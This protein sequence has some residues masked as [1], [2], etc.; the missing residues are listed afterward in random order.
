MVNTSLCLG[1]RPIDE[2]EYAKWMNLY[3]LLEE[4]RP[5][6]YP[7]TPHITLAYYSPQ[8]FNKLLCQKLQ[9]CVRKFNE[10]SSFSITLTTDNLYYQK[11]MSMNEYYNIF[12]LIP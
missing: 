6:P 11:F 10:D 4:I 1:L 8:G 5:L 9:K 12:K 2:E 7:S 3:N